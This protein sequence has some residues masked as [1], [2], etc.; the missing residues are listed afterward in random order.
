[1]IQQLHIKQIALS[2]ALLFSSI[3]YTKAQ[4]PTVA[5]TF[6]TQADVN[7][8]PATYPTC[9][10]I[11]DGID[12]KI[13]G[14]DITDLSPLS[15][16]TSILGAFEIRNCPLLTNLNGLNNMT[17]SGN[18]PLDGFILRDLPALTSITAL[19]NLNS[20]TGE[21]TIRTCNALT[22]LN[23]LN[24]LTTVNGSVIIRDNATLQNFNGL[25]A[26]NYIGETLEIVENAQLNNITALSNVNTI[27]GGIEG[28][29][30]IEANTV[31][32]NL[33]G[34]GNNTTMIGGNLDILLNDNLY[35]CSVP[36]ICNYLASPPVGATITIN[37][38]SV[39]CNTQP[40]IQA[41]CISLSTTEVL[42]DK[43]E[44]T[45][46]PNPVL[47]HFKIETKHTQELTIEIFD[48][49]GRKLNAFTMKEQYECDVV[50]YPKGIYF[51][52]TTTRTGK[53]KIYKIVKP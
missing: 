7:A 10:V 32:T 50:N 6:A 35:L 24:N 44:I 47:E 40:E 1:M 27:V 9:T 16:I 48:V 49:Y 53:E 41:N 51:I 2:V 29:I 39:G 14:S 45:I 17:V 46:S 28:G 33:T 31:L 26:L 3:Q 43:H 21:F 25:N 36:S 23:G 19:S 15:Q 38:N 30:F 13:M 11:P 5:L 18:D 20:I 4:C 34:L 12:V 22:S 8:F 42:M 52:K 37:T